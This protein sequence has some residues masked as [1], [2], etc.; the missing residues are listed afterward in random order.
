M[1]KEAVNKAINEQINAE[2]HSAYLYLSMSAYFEAAG[3]SGFANWMKVQYKEEL[4]HAQKFFD[5]VNDR[6]AR[7]ILSPIAEVPAEFKNVVDV[8]EKTLA[9]EQDITE[10]INNLMDISIAESD[11]ATKSFLQWFLDEQVEEENTVDQ[12]LNNLKL[13]NG[14][15]QGLLMMD[16]EMMNRTFSDPTAGA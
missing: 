13:I 3:L 16:R 7:V 2:F 14:D 6:G 8:F 5:Y 12:I 10:R 1:L 15:G 4:A 11:H 9:H